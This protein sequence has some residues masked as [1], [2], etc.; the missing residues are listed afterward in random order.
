MYEHAI[1][2]GYVIRFSGCCENIFQ[3]KTA[4]PP[5]KNLPICLCWC[6]RYWYSCICQASSSYIAVFS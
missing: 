3:A 5:G 6:A 4:Q 2:S 1:L